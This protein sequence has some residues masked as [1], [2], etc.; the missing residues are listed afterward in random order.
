M[1]RINAC[2]RAGKCLGLKTV[3]DA[4]VR[5]VPETPRTAAAGEI[6][7]DALLLLR[8]AARHGDFLPGVE[9]IRIA[10]TIAIAVVQNGP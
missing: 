10:Q 7:G 1:L 2:Q 3:E 5:A 6:A 8:I 4:A 9:H